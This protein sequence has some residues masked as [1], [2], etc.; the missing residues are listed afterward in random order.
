MRCLNNFPIKRKICVDTVTHSWY[1]KKHKGEMKMAKGCSCSDCMS[2]QDAADRGFFGK[3]LHCAKEIMLFL[4]VAF[5]TISI[6]AVYGVIEAIALYIHRVYTTLT[7]FI[8]FE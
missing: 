5:L 7:D 4:I 3:L 6:A 1:I 2:F 8:D